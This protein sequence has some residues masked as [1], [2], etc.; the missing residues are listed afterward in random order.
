MV[1]RFG[2]EVID[3]QC[4]KLEALRSPACTDGSQDEGFE[5]LIRK[6]WS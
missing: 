1:A 2:D 3:Y 5:V 4:S 6:L